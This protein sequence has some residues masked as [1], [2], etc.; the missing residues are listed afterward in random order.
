MLY[1]HREHPDKRSP[2]RRQYEPMKEKA[3]AQLAYEYWERRGRPFGS[4]E[5]D[6]FRA[7]SD[8]DAQRN[9]YPN[10]TAVS[11]IQLFPSQIAYSILE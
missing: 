1:E 10:T 9:W 5:V 7:E 8:L 6:W 11:G 4:P 3:I 2:V